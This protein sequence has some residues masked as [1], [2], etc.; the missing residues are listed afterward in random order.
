MDKKLLE[1]IANEAPDGGFSG[2][3]EYKRADEGR[4]MAQPWMAQY[5]VWNPDPK[6]E[7]TAENPATPGIVMTEVSGNGEARTKKV[8]I[9]QK[10]RAVIL[11]TSYGRQL[12]VK[13]GVFKTLCQSHD[14]VNPSLR[15]DE[16]LCRKIS[17][18][19]VAKIFSQWKGYDEAAVKEK[20]QEVTQGTDKLQ[21]CGLK[22][23]D[24]FITLC[25]Y[26][27]KDPITKAKAACRQH[28][29]VHAYDIDRKREFKMTLTGNSI[30]NDQRFVSPFHEFFLFLRTQ[31]PQVNGRPASLPCYA[32]SVELSAAPRDRFFYLNLLNY[33]P[34]EQA[35]N[36][37]SMKKRAEEAR[38]KYEKDAHR[39]SK[40]EFEKIRNANQSTGGAGAGV[41]PPTAPVVASRPPPA[42]GPAPSPLPDGTVD[43]GEP[44][45]FDEDDIDF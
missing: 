3:L 30:Q 11:F 22:T 19:D 16:P 33:K 18:V 14:G 20:T 27:K 4:S 32:F 2:D 35:E 23:K 31:G 45:S 24:G 10:I 12:S 9:A 15:I 21:I 28:V 1:E 40:A 25:P 37:E 29:F 42:N 6:V 17:G 44:V 13:D 38:D 43:L 7:Y 41:P 36:R 39:L 5:K 26:G 34:I 8:E